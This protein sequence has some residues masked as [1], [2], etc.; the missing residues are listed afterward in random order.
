MSSGNH[1]DKWIDRWWPLLL[2]AFGA[3]FIG[4]L[5]FFHPYM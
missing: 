2:I 3:T 5:V 4:T 1:T